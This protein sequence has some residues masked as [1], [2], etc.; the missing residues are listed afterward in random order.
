MDFPYG[1]PVIA[2]TVLHYVLAIVEGSFDGHAMHIV[3]LRTRPLRQLR[4]NS[5]SVSLVIFRGRF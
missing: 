1:N 3:I 2:A 4:R 5:P